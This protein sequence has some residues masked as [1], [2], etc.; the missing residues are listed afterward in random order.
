MTF[1]L[2]TGQVDDISSW[3]NPQ[4]A[5]ETL[6]LI[7]DSADTSIPMRCYLST[8]RN[9]ADI[10]NPREADDNYENSTQ[11]LAKLAV[12]LATSKNAEAPPRT[13]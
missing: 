12:K 8:I 9:N 5:Q 11:V 3:W 2:K 1:L 4:K 10:E 13:K 7:D 6:D